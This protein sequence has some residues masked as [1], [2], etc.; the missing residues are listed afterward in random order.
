M[1]QIAASSTLFADA[2]T[3]TSLYQNAV[4]AAR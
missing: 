2:A 1:Q 4:Q 3:P